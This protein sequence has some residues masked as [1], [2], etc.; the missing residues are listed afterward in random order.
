MAGKSTAIAAPRTSKRAEIAK[1][2][3]TRITDEKI[4]EILSYMERGLSERQACMAVSVNP[5]SFRQ[6]VARNTINTQYARA[7]EVQ[8][9][10]QIESI[11]QT[12][13]DMRDGI[14]DPQ[15]ARVEIDTRKWLAS[16]L[17]PKKYGDKLDLTSDGKALPQPLLGGVTIEAPKELPE[18]S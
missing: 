6:A 17:L 9:I 16:K 14:V 2:G 13:Q 3:Y 15:M 4:V 1:Q 7:L 18:N 10:A 8:A 12:L 5:S 11:E